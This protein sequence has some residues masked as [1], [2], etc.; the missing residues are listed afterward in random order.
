[1]LSVALESTV[2][3]LHGR[4]L[5]WSTL[6]SF[7]VFH[8]SYSESTYKVSSYSHHMSPRLG[9][10]P[11]HNICSSGKVLNLTQCVPATPSQSTDG[12]SI[13]YLAL[14]MV[15]ALPPFI[16]CTG[17]RVTLVPP[18]WIEHG[19][20]WLQI[21]CSTNWAIRAI[22]GSSTWAR[23]R[24]NLINSQVLYQLSYQGI[25]TMV[26]VGRIEL[27]SHGPKPRILPLNYTELKIGGGW[28][29]RTP[30]NSLQSC[31]N[32]IILIPH[33]ETILFSILSWGSIQ[34]RTS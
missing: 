29:D 15:T 28:E 33:I 18:P 19:T 20:T 27:P 3:L 30:I 24:D 6:A 11:V 13:E 26:S 25:K 5:L 12:H 4:S 23:T 16:T 9:S 7:S 8:C 31:R 2:A 21:R 14:S 1:M 17:S 34:G 22:S 10:C 32:P